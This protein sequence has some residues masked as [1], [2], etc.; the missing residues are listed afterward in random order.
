MFSL[1]APEDSF[2]K[3]NKHLDRAP[4]TILPLAILLLYHR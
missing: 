2:L 3:Y 1:G 4:V